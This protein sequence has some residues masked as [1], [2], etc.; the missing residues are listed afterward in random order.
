[1]NIKATYQKHPVDIFCNNPL[2]E[3]LAIELDK[4]RLL[5][6]VTRIV[7][8]ENFWELHEI[9]QGALLLE[10]RKTH[11][12]IP[13]FSAMYNKFI[14]LILNSY[15]DRNP[16]LAKTA[17]LKH[18]I[19]SCYRDPKAKFLET[20]TLTVTTAASVVIH[21]LSAT[22][23]T[24]GIR[25]VLSRIDQVIEHENYNDNVYRQ[26]QL[27]WISIDLPSTPSIKA[28]ALNFFLAV[29]IAL[30]NT[31]YYQEWSSKAH[32]SVD[33]HLN[34]M[35]IVACTCEVGLV[36]IDEIQFLLKYPKN[37]NTPNL[38][39]IEA[40]FNKI[41]IPMVLSTTTQGL[42]IF[43]APNDK[44]ETLQPDITTVRRMLS[45]REFKVDIIKRPSEHFNII[46]KA[47]FPGDLLHP[48]MIIDEAFVAKF[49]FLSCGLPA[50]MTRLA[51]L[52]HETVVQFVAGS[53]KL[54]SA[55]VMLNSVYQ[56]QF[57]IIAPSLRLL[58]ANQPGLYETR[59]LEENSGKQ[60]YTNSEQK[61]LTKKAK[62]TLKAVMKGGG[63]E[64]DP[65]NPAL[66]L[67]SPALA[68]INGA[69]PNIGEAI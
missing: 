33:L 25:T 37:V 47:L 13:Q 59:L 31:S 61:S 9:Y 69:N 20:L 35:A 67:D 26:Q 14:G 10:I 2:T 5:E 8:V 45:D 41:G 39:I 52:F 28:L 32:M 54:P 3:A 16:L 44:S 4:N 63:L 17:K 30:K 21:G 38:Q 12:P 58:R 46:F 34:A 7:K 48:G 60:C 49:Y 27:V 62:K 65:H 68:T 56:N 51:Q 50:I 23:K 40:L 53:K 55:L 19:A 42:E 11:I 57:S 18:D 22:G 15:A 24:T 29:D 6:G 43:A 66:S 64:V 36:H 1:M